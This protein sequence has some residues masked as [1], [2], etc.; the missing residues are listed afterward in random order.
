MNSSYLPST[1][2]TAPS[3]CELLASARTSRDDY[4]Q[5]T[6]IG[7]SGSRLVIAQHASLLSMHYVE[8]N[9]S[10]SSVNGSLRYFLL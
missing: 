10:T 7:D 5:I 4:S 3:Y 6:F 1:K 2:A 9:G 8:A